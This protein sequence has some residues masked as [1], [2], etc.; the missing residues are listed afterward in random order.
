MDIDFWEGY[1]MVSRRIRLRGYLNSIEGRELIASGLVRV[2]P[3][4]QDLLTPSR[5]GPQQQHNTTT[6]H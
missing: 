4:D 3:D 1:D 2:H 6:Q 5:V